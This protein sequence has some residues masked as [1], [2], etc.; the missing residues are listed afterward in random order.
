M[1][2]SDWSS[3]VCSPDLIGFEQS[4]AHFAHGLAHVLFPER[5]AALEAIENAAEPVRQIFKH[6]QCHSKSGPKARNAKNAGG[7][8]LVSQRPSIHSRRFTAPKHILIG[9]G[10]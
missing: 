5:T 7:R 6:R 2:I 1:R 8:T 4:D 10:A 3:D 9:G